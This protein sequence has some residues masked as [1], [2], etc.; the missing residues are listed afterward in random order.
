MVGFA[1]DRK[2]VMSLL[3]TLLV[4]GFLLHFCGNSFASGGEELPWDQGL[5]KLVK[6]LS[7]KT[8][9]LVTCIGLFVLAGMAIFGGDLGV[10]GKGL[11]MVILA[12]S[13]LG[14]LMQVAKFF[15]GTG[16]VL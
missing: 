12:G 15:I 2:F 1:I 9:L 11:M 3:F 7:G 13:I 5:D 14:G 4:L 16:A 10:V 8:A 6:A